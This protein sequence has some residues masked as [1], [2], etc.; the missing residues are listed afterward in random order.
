M[1]KLLFPYYKL[2]ISTADI[3]LV[4]LLTYRLF[5][6]LRRSHAMNLIKGLFLLFLIFLTS[7]ILGLTTL[8][9]VLEKF[10]TVVLILVII[11]FQPELRQFLER[12]G[13]TGSL[14]SSVQ[15]FFEVSSTAFIQQLV[16]GVETLSKNKIG[17]IIVLEG[18]T[19]LKNYIDSG[20]KIGGELNADIISTLFWPG[21]PTHDGA[22]IVKDG[23]I[24]AA[25]CYLPLTETPIPDRRIG[26]RHRAALGLSETTDAFIIV[27][28][29]ESGIIS[30]AENGTLT[31]YLTKES[32]ETQLFNI[33][34]TSE[35][36]RSKVKKIFKF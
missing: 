18:T 32:L 16:R 34:K 17:A 25:S 12:V 19:S 31:R 22:I 15:P 35:A 33:F 8:N 13:S 30:I 2:L 20:I 7:N 10:A 14:F 1:L 36:K 6:W 5:S 27:V 9:W 21:T 11:I 24:E 29:E 4:Y 23:S 28:S 3:L 26:T